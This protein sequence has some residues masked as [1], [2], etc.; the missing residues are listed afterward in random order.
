MGR[1]AGPAPRPNGLINIGSLSALSTLPG[2]TGTRHRGNAAQHSETTRGPTTVSGEEV[3]VFTCLREAHLG[4]QTPGSALQAPRYTLQAPRYRLHATGYR[5]HATGSRLQAPG[6]RHAP[7]HAP[8][9][10]QPQSLI[11]PGQ[12]R[13]LKPVTK[14]THTHTHTHTPQTSLRNTEGTG[15]SQILVSG[16]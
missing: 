9:T 11:S 8:P 14:H 13:L 16:L 3:R 15:F 5:L 4:P 10:Q 1:A 6:S 2:R 7:A 12:V